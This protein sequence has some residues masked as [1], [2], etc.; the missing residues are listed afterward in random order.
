MKFDSK[1]FIEDFY[2]IAYLFCFIIYLFILLQNSQ[3]HF[4][5]EEEIICF[6]NDKYTA[7][8]FL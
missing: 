4:V 3:K 6:L 7:M 8:L 1:I 2:F 5:F